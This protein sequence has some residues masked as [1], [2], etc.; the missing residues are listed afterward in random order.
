MVFRYF[1][2]GGAA[3]GRLHNTVTDE[4]NVVIVNSGSKIPKFD[5]F[6]GNLTN[7]NIMERKE[8]KEILV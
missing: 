6:G 3:L 7:E 1:A 8:I 4:S 5:S 2:G